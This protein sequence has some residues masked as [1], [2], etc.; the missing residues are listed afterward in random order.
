MTRHTKEEVQKAARNVKPEGLRD[1][2]A[3]TYEVSGY[4]AI[5]PEEHRRLAKKYPS[6]T[7]CPLCMECIECGLIVHD[8]K[9]TQHK[10]TCSK[11]TT[12][13]QW[14][15]INAVNGVPEKKT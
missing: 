5:S 6:S 13:E 9:P 8:K 3:G 14:D 4:K 2:D 15:F 11:R 12:A 1:V 7:A 10:V